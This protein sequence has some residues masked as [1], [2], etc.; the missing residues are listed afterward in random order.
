[1]KIKVKNDK[2]YMVEVKNILYVFTTGSCS[3]FICKSADEELFELNEEIYRQGLSLLFLNSIENVN[4]KTYEIL[5]L[6]LLMDNKELLTDFSSNKEI[7]YF[8]EENKDLIDFCIEKIL[9]ETNTEM[10]DIFNLTNMYLKMKDPDA[11]DMEYMIVWNIFGNGICMSSWAM[12]HA[13]EETIWDIIKE[14][15][16][17]D[18]VPFSFE[19]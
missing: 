2:N 16:I 7:R 3:D 14:Y 13:N 15:T 5:L 8:Y 10:L 18:E 9:R 1:M 4:I 17:F 19:R 12:D 6:I 11:I